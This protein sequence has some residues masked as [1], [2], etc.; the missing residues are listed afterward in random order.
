M[1][2]LLY[3]RRWKNFLRSWSQGSLITLSQPQLHFLVG[4]RATLKMFLAW[5]YFYYL[6]GTNSTYLLNWAFLNTL[7]LEIRESQ[8]L[9]KDFRRT[10][11]G[12]KGNKAIRKKIYKFKKLK[13]Y[14]EIK[15]NYNNQKEDK[16]GRKKNKEKKRREKKQFLRGIDGIDG[17]CEFAARY[18]PRAVHASR[19]TRF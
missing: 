7:E 16:K 5:L 11:R 12:W 19:A 8:D 10:A 17:R 2:K 15:Q 18:D 1:A 9:V 3:F 13:Q 6:V 14:K 4:L